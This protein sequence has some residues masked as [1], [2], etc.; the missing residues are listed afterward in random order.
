MD[1]SLAVLV[2]NQGDD[3]IACLNKAVA[4]LIAIASSRVITQ[5]VQGRQGQSYAGSGYQGNTTSFGGNNA[6]GASDGQSFQLWF[7]HYLRDEVVDTLVSMI[8]ESEAVES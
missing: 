7:K 5:Q 6:G 1:S 3:P 4:F 2:F 8:E